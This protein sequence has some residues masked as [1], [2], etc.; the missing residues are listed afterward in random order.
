VCIQNKIIIYFW[1]KVYAY[2]D[3]KN[4]AREK[5]R[6]WRQ[7]RMNEMGLVPACPA[8]MKGHGADKGSVIITIKVK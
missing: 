8:G 2:L 3:S 5:G 4:Y 1:I 7:D 6:E